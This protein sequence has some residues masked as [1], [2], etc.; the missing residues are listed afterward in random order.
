MDKLMQN[1]LINSRP[2]AINAACAGGRQT[3]VLVTTL[4]QWWMCAAQIKASQRMWVLT[5]APCT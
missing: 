2:L 3:P 4:D 5:L 1:E